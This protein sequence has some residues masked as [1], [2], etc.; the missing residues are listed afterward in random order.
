MIWGISSRAS[1]FVSLASTVGVS[2]RVV[3]L[4][5]MQTMNKLNFSPN[6]TFDVTVP[7][8]AS[9]IRVRSGLN[10]PHLQNSHSTRKTPILRISFRAGGS[11]DVPRHTTP[12]GKGKPWS[13]VYHARDLDDSTTTGAQQDPPG[14]TPTTQPGG[15]EPE[16]AP[17]VAPVAQNETTDGDDA[18]SAISS[19]S[20]PPALLPGDSYETLICGG[21]VA[22]IATLKRYAGTKGFRMVVPSEQAGEFKVLGED[23]EEEE[24]EEE[25]DV[26]GDGDQG[27]GVGTKRRASGTGIEDEQANKRPRAEE[28]TFTSSDT[29]PPASTSTRPISSPNR[30]TA[31]PIN[32]LAQSILSDPTAHGDVFL[33][34]GWRERWCRCETCYPSL[35]KHPFLLEEEETYEPPQDPDAG[36]SLEELGMRALATLPHEQALDSIRAYNAMRDDLMLYLR[37]FADSGRE[38]REEDITA[39]FQRRRQGRV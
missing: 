16:S 27:A 23:W 5:V 36:L 20:L 34:A 9:P 1:I 18:D 35:Q 11:V 31:P 37:P 39:F 15:G 8:A 12:N 24:G 38:V 3:R 33:S 25:V 29:N 17:P 19:T 28:S 6:G 4:A 13:N 21:C 10:N 7:Q 22:K 14:V 30:C 26:V 2:V 32:S